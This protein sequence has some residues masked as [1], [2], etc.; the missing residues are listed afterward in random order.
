MNVPQITAEVRRV[1][2]RVEAAFARGTTAE[3]LIPMWYDEDV[4]V[5]G[6]G[7]PGAVRGHAEVIAKAAQMLPEMGP[8]PRAS[9]RMDEPVLGM[10]SLAVVFIDAEVSPDIAGAQ[11]VRYRILTAWRPGKR[12]WR[13]VREMFTS[14]TL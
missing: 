7:D 13:I 10:E 3:E 11:P 4:V 6:E 14:G 1:L 2:D 5:V 12:G 9:F 8:H